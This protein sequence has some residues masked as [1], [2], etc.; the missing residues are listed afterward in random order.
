MPILF[1]VAGAVIGI[2]GVFWA[3]GLAVG[4]GTRLAVGLKAGRTP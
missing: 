2:S 1:G 3:V 4:A